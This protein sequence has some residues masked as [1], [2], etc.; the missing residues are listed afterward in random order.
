MLSKENIMVA[1]ENFAHLYFMHYETDEWK[2]IKE[3]DIVDIPKIV[4]Q[5]ISIAIGKEYPSLFREIMDEIN[6][7]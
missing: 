3:E 1:A 2:V 5:A 4:R 7:I 6:V